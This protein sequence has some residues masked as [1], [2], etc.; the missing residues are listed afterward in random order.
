M[1]CVYRIPFF[2]SST[3]IFDK[4][5]A[6]I[7]SFLELHPHPILPTTLLWQVRIQF[8][9]LAQLAGIM[10]LRLTLHFHTGS[11]I[12]I[13]SLVDLTAM[14][15]RIACTCY[16]RRQGSRPRK[17][18]AAKK[19][20]RD[21]LKMNLGWILHDLMSTM[22]AFLPDICLLIPILADLSIL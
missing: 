21:I 8:P 10:N 16:W 2:S 6:Y 18:A 1:M 20:P 3:L 11:L 15:R 17:L 4:S 22:E 5:L 9:Q 14:P 7:H 19:S 13:R 12:I